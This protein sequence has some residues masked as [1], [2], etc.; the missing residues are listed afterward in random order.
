MRHLEFIALTW[1]VASLTGCIS[2]YRYE[3]RGS[4]EAASGG[5]RGALLY[6]YEDDGR[7]WYGKRYRARDSDVDLKI[8][9]ATD[10]T[11]VPASNKDLLLTLKSR[12][13]D[14]RI[15]ELASDGRVEPIEPPEPL[16]AGQSCGHILVGGRQV[17]MEALDPGARPEVAILCLNRRV[18]D[19][20]PG[21]SLYPFEALTRTKVKEDREPSSPCEPPPQ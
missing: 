16:A 17:D 7:L 5:S 1:L 4:V 14:V 8:C 21:A 18:S 3:S 12:G 10:K 2:T 20:Y 6:Y 9:E 11:F 13:G 15:A 19:R